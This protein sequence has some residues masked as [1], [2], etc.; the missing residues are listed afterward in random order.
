MFRKHKWL[1]EAKSKEK[2]GRRVRRRFNK[3]ERISARWFDSALACGEFPVQT[4]E[5]RKNRFQLGND[6]SWFG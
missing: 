1:E 4:K 2:G 5:M 3:E 6:Q